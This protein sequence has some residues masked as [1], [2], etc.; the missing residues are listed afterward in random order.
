M[1]PRPFENDHDDAA[2][3]AF[4]R[5]SEA[6]RKS[7]AE[8]QQRTRA[9][10]RVRDFIE[11]ERAKRDR[12]RYMQVRLEQLARPVDAE[13]DAEGGRLRQLSNAELLAE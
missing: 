2:A 1:L 3:I 6:A 10:G 9:L 5:L 12:G 13:I 4:G 7:F 11:H 8:G